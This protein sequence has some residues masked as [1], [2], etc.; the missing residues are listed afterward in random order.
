MEQF[1]VPSTIFCKASPFASTETIF[2][3]VPGNLSGLGLLAVALVLAILTASVVSCAT[4]KKSLDTS[5]LSDLAS[6]VLANSS[7]NGSPETGPANLEAYLSA[8]E[9][10]SL[11]M[12]SYRLVSREPFE[13]WKPTVHKGK[14]V[15]ERLRFRPEAI[16]AVARP[17]AATDSYFYFFHTADWTGKKAV[18]WAPGFGVS[19]FAVLFIRRFF[20]MELSRGWAVLVWVPPYHLERQSPGK[21]PGEDLITLDPKSLLLSMAA[22]VGELAHGVAWLAS[23]GVERVGGWGGSFGAASLMLLGEHYRFDHLAL[24]IPL[25]DWTTPWN[26]EAL[27]PLRQAFHSAGYDE[28]LL[29]R[30]FR[31]IS[32]VARGALTPPGRTQI[33]YA[34]YDQLTP[35]SVTLA[36]G[37][38]LQA[39]SIGGAEKPEVLG[40]N[41]SHGTIL[42]RG[43]MYRAYGEFLDRM[44]N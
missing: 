25:V 13:R 20:E 24:M 42:L 8:S 22:S 23:Q 30:A 38:A 15:G 44:D 7:A 31:T 16:D 10:A 18:I 35:E 27:A 1:K 21:K 5:S 4:F 34:R 14:V 19:D 37:Q 28:D 12:V 43:A 11:T 40:Y 17:V 26:N 32:P 29:F 9:S 6:Q 36:H 41:E 3:S 39:Q 33:L 2:I